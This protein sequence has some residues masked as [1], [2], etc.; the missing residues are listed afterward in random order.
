VSESLSPE[1]G[2]ALVASARAY[3]NTPFAHLGRKRGA[4]VDC[5]GLIACA[6]RDIGI[7]IPDVMLYSPQPWPTKMLEHL[8]KIATRLDGLSEMEPGC[9]LLLWIVRPRLPQ[10]LAIWTG[11]GTILH[12]WAEAN[13]VCESSF[14]PYWESHVHSC[15]KIKQWQP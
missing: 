5:G 10:H 7:E 8:D 9:L 6:S 14:D 3:I 1:Q 4:G 15:W 11:E 2:R 12:S 13:K